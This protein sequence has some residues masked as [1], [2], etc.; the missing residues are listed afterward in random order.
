MA[1]SLVS[2]M[3][4]RESTDDESDTKHSERTTFVRPR[5]LWAEALWGVGL[6]GSVLICVALIAAM[7][8]R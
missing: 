3:P 1:E 5:A 2:S 7:F 6:I 4:T 8:G